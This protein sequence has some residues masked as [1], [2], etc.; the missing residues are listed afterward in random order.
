MGTG[1]TSVG[2]ILAKKLKKTARDV[3]QMIEQKEKISI[4][5]IFEKE[6]EAAFRNLEKETIKLVSREENV[7]ITTGGGAVLDPENLKAL[8]EKGW[9]VALHASP[10]MIYKRV[11]NSKKRPLLQGQ[12]RVHEIKRLL[13][14]RKP[15]Y[16]RADFSVDTDGTSAAQVAAKI[17][18]VLED[19]K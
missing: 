9:I 2:K 5:E 1:K 10:E 12:N 11:K 15:L 19:K 7:V 16:H 8:S 6:G 4:K 13:E 18:R 14:I 3:D 17:L